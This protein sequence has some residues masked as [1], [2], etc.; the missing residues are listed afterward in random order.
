ME[1]TIPL[2]FIPQV[3]LSSSDAFQEGLTRPQLG[4]L[5]CVYFTVRDNDVDKLLGFLQRHIS[6]KA[7]VEASA[8]TSTDSIISILDAG[9]RTVFVQASRL[10]AL[11]TY[12]DRIALSASHDG[13]DSG[14]KA[15]G[16][17]LLALGEDTSIFKS[18]LKAFVESKTSPIFVLAGSTNT[19]QEYTGLAKEHGA[20]PIIPAAQLTIE[21]ASESGKISVPAMIASQWASDRSD[22]LVPTV[23]TDERG[24]ALGLVYSSQESLSESLKTGTGMV[25]AHVFLNNDS[26]LNTSRRLSESK[27]RLMVQGCNFWRYPSTH[28]GIA[29]L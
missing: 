23:V 27:A 15:A 14:A 16:G 3:D 4:Y 26:N 5:G 24:I 17:V 9:A 19:E 2:P 28:S 1:T 11:Q 12:G 22:K 25:N 20:I 8:L 6:I 10:E 7:Y 29:G 18:A 13:S 21:N